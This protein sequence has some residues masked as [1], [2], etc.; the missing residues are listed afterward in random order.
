MRLK[1]IESSP[2]LN[3][4]SEVATRLPPIVN[5]QY[6]NKKIQHLNQERQKI[7]ELAAK[8]KMEHGSPIKELRYIETP[9]AD[10]LAF[11]AQKIIS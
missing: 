2:Q 7:H 5:E 6:L 11:Q 9:Y 8:Y 1:K 10:P 4:V 3:L